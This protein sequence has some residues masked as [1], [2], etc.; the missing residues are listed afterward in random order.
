MAHMM[1]MLVT[2]R[3]RLSASHG[4][5]DRQ[6]LP[7]AAFD[8]SKQIENQNL[9]AFKDSQFQGGVEITPLYAHVAHM[10]PEVNMKQLYSYYS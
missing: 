3:T 1:L 10:M 7:A 9:L 6:S 8:W 4:R 2:L 5:S